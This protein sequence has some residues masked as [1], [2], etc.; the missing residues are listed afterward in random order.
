MHV[1]HLFSR[2]ISLMTSSILLQMM[3]IVFFSE[4]LSEE[5]TGCYSYCSIVKISP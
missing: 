1:C 4:L 3:G 5:I 2:E